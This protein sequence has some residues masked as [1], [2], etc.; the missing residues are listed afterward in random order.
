[1][2]AGNQ[3]ALEVTASRKCAARQMRAAASRGMIGADTNIYR[4]EVY[5]MRRTR[6]GMVG[7][8]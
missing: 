3:S 4:G 2:P 1:M 8:E 5:S 7:P 6:C